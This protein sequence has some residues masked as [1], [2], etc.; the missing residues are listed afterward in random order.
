MRNIIK[1][2]AL[3]VSITMPTISCAMELEFKAGDLTLRDVSMR[4]TMPGRP[5]AAYV[6]VIND[7]N[8]ADKI[9]SAR[10]VERGFL[11]CN[12]GRD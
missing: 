8:Q 2:A 6:T 12:R 9:V 1:A 7:G 3:A 10:T 11:R 4:A 5:G